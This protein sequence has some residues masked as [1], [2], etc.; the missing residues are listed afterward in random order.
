MLHP[1]S[2][3]LTV[4]VTH[5]D[6]KWFNVAL[7]GFKGSLGHQQKFVDDFLEEFIEWASSYIDDIVVGSRTFK[8]HHDHLSRLFAKIE[9]AKLALNPKKCFLGFQRIQLLGHIVDRFGIYTMKSKA[10][11]IR[12]MLF[13]ATLADLE[14][15]LS[16]I[17]YYR[18]F[19]TF[20]SLRAPLLRKL[21]TELSKLIRKP[22]QR[23]SAKADT[24]RVP[25]PTKEQIASFE[26]LKEALSREQFLIHED[27]S[28]PLMLAI[29]VSYEYGFG[30]A[31]Y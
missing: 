22:D 9:L 8:E 19:V 7:L 26:Q 1:E 14:Y 10:A 5:R 30:M 21:A 18:Q 25:P 16:L 13:P 28:V 31:V 2:Q 29:D 12:G 17:G 11:A 23:R 20:Y 15:F 24:V 3:P 4:V 6:H 27:P